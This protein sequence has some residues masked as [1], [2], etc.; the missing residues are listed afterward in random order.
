MV[1]EDLV[2]NTELAT[3]P[4]STFVIAPIIER[5]QAAFRRDLP[6]LMKSHYRQWVAYHGE[7][8]IGLARSSFDLY[9]ACSRRGL[10]C[11]E[12]VVRSIEPEMPEEISP[13]ELLDS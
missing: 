3:S 4:V 12:F 11:G 10:K 13:D 1:V 2:V 5:S 7:Q 8:Q 6:E 9:D